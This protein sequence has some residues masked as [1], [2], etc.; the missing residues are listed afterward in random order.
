MTVAEHDPT[1][2]GAPGEA[3]PRA[4]H[5]PWGTHAAFLLL[6][7]L[8]APVHFLGLLPHFSTHILGDVM[9]AAEYPWNEFWTAHA[10][11]DLGTNPFRT[12]YMFYPV[13]I[14]LVQH[15]Y[16][17][18]DGLLYTLARP[19]VPLLVFHNALTWLSVFL[20]SAAAY[21]LLCS[22]TGLSGLAFIGAV[23]FAH[24][25][26]LTSYYGPQ[27]LIEPYLFVFFVLASIR[28]FG[29]LHP[30]G[31]VGAGILLG[32]SVYTYPYYF[33]AGLLWLAILGLDRLS[34]LAERPGS[35]GLPTRSVALS[36]IF[37]GLTVASI[38]ALVLMPKDWWRSARLGR[39]LRTDYVLGVALLAYLVVKTASR[40]ARSRGA[41][42]AAGA[43][44]SGSAV[45]SAAAPLSGETEGQAPDESSVRRPGGATVSA[46]LHR[47]PL[48]RQAALRVLLIVL[49]VAVSGVV[50]AFPYS[51]SYLTD[52]AVRSAVVSPPSEFLDQSVDVVSFFA[53]FHPSLS[54]L[55]QRVALD[56]HRGRPI[57][58]TPAFLGW[59]WLCLLV[60]AFALWPR[61]P[62]L[63]V[64]IGAWTVFLLLCL[65]P[66]LKIHGIIHRGFVLPGDILPSLPVLQSARTLSRFLVPLVLFTIVI[67]CLLL[68]DRLAGA[69]QRRRVVWYASALFV[70]ALEYALVLYPVQAPRANYQV[71]AVYHFLAETARGKVGVLLDLPLLTHSGRRSEGRG[72]TRSH[73]YQTV[74]RQKLIGGVSS[75]LPDEVFAFFEAI[76]GRQGLLV[77]IGNRRGSA[78]G[79]TRRAAGGLDRPKQGV[80]RA[81]D[82]AR[83]PGDPPR[84][85]LSDAVLRGR[86]LRRVSRG[87]I[88]DLREL[89]IQAEA[90]GQTREGAGSRV[91]R[92]FRR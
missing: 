66:R 9:D 73:Y 61:R 80:V 69:T 41:R 91:T 43:E 20:N 53:P 29:T 40:L 15:T 88:E 32:L 86:R 50:V 22:L 47:V 49:L 3:R 70:V 23:A 75:V 65:G 83:L 81:G 54:P 76:P 82:A 84:E 51:V 68:K 52:V 19:L 8:L 89:P 34:P 79:L 59:F 57:V 56:W 72:Q 38:L 58:G 31:A 11:L 67:G 77:A 60:L 87:P 27:G 26:V 13:G 35:P 14:N 45:S 6:L 44:L 2:A 33:V 30:G 39:Y 48:C 10:L 71:P 37:T 36:V 4:R 90:G 12:D 16:T 18:L 1:H 21:A 62:E 74:H 25:P 85:P 55:Y 7:F 78:G 24:S 64:W 92:R 17:F 28:V 46:S 63:G 42:D 5:A